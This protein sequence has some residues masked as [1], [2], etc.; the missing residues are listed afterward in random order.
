M[1]M[2]QPIEPPYEAAG[3]SNK[4]FPIE[5]AVNAQLK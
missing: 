5:Y 1:A 4:R 3:L 2:P